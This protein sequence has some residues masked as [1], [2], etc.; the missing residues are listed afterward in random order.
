M[1]LAG[2]R[3]KGLAQR[4]LDI[5]LGNDPAT[6]TGPVMISRVAAE[7]APLAWTFVLDHLKEVNAKLDAVQRVTFVPSIGAQSLDAT[8]MKQLREFIDVK[9][10]EANKA[11]VEKFYA[12]MA[13]RLSVRDQRIPDIDAW[14]AANG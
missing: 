9:V 12:D 14:L 4:S 1:A 7:N 5:A 11:Q 10:P 8:I 3:D 6:A 2:A 13:F